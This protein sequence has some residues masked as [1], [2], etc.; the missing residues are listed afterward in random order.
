[1]QPAAGTGPLRGM[2]VLEVGGIGPTPFAAMM[3]ADMGAQVVRIE[4][5]GAPIQERGPTTRGRL[6]LDLDLKDGAACAQV[7]KLA[8]FSDVLIEGFRPGVMERLGLG[9]E[10]LCSANPK[11][12]YARMTGWGQSGPLAHTAGH[13]IDY[14]AITGAL[15]AIGHADREPAVPL[16]LVG[17]YGAG[18]MYL[19]AGILAASLEAQ[20][21]G[22]G[23][24]V[25]AAI[26]DGAVSMMSLFH[27]LRHEGRWRDERESNLIDGGAPFYRT[28]ECKDGRHLAVGAIE[29]Q[30]YARL[31]HLAGWNDAV[32]DD[33]GDASN[34][35]AMASKAQAIM[36]TRT[37]DEWMQLFEGTDACVA[38]VL[39][40]GESPSHPHLQARGCFV[41]LEGLRQP[42]PAPRY[43]RTPSQARA[44]TRASGIEEVITLWRQPCDAR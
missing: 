10:A 33:P 23:Q 11:L 25:D 31:R 24:V 32:F 35:R 42:A 14:I 9:P 44:S 43:S 29:P 19:L 38:P 37:R 7:R 17:D 1:M 13:D 26:C 27:H 16:N 28:Y 40:L 36:R 15:H 8:G 20:R 6:L 41:E 4:R 34:W 18:A 3:L 5:A 30:F 22:R 2:R 39:S 12:V 21:S